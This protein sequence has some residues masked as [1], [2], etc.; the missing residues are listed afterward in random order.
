ML[1]VRVV[2]ARDE[3]CK[4][5]RVAAL[6]ILQRGL[7]N[8]KSRFE[9]PAG[10]LLLTEPCL[11]D[12]LPLGG[13]GQIGGGALPGLPVRALRV[14]KTLFGG[15]AEGGGLRRDG[16]KLGL[17]TRE[18]IE[19]GGLRRVTLVGAAQRRL[20]RQQSLLERRRDP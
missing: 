5:G 17:S 10:L 18:L 13:R 14:R 6:C 16:T 20:E 8:G 1:R 15:S 12:R 7:R 2:Q 3:R 4:M 9:R 19:R 11:E